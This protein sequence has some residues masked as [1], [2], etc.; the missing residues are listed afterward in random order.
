MTALAGDALSHVHSHVLFQCR[1]GAFNDQFCCKEFA[2]PVARRVPVKSAKAIC[3]IGNCMAAMTAR[4]GT[5]SPDSFHL[6]ITY[7]DLT[8]ILIYSNYKYSVG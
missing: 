7:T 8:D 1:R 6:T 2:M 3:S 4:I 5:R